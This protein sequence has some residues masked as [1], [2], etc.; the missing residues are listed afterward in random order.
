MIYL[1][2]S[3]EPQV[4][5]IPR[6][7]ML[8]P[9]GDYVL[10]LK[11]SLDRS[12]VSMT[13]S[14]VTAGALNYTVTIALP[15]LLPAGEYSYELRQGAAVAAVGI[16]TLGEYEYGTTQYEAGTTYEQYGNE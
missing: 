14:C 4:V 3:T 1:E 12:R 15:D 2:Q 9:G 5:K 8:M 13:P 10:T 11:N 7:L 6:N 16:L